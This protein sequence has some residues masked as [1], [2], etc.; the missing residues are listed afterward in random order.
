ALAQ[1]GL[2]THTLVVA[3]SH[4]PKLDDLAIIAAL[5]S[6]AAY[7]G[8]MGSART[9]AARREWLQTHFGF[10]DQ[11]L[12]RLRAPIGLDIGSKTPAEIAVSI[13]ADLIGVR[14]GKTPAK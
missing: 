3:L 1:L 6:K 4:D 11:S 9:S 8:A 14:R 12:A 7:V 2:D 5:D 13:V 10:S